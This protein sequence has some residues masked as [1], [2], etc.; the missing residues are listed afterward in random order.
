MEIW[1]DT[2]NVE[3]IRTANEWGI[4][5][6]VTTNTTKIAN[7]KRSFREIIDEICRIMGDKPVSVM[8]VQHR[9]KKA[10]EIVKDG[11]ELVEWHPNIVVK[12]PPTIEG[13]K[14]VKILSKQGIKTNITLVYTVSQALLSAKMGATYVSPFV[15]RM[16]YVSHE[17]LEQVR[18]I[19]KVF[20]NYNFKTKIVLAAVRHP[21]HFVKGALIGV[22]VVT[23]SFSIL[24]MLY[25]H[26]L[27]DKGLKQFLEDWEKVPP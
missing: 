14:A 11:K 5:D 20:D 27:T 18:M 10:E 15:G 22:D 1:A 9:Y 8:A 12:V 26:P 23:A 21:I 24:K 16:D 13:L 2:A 25:E 7:E 17:G 19:R 6:G 4:I 3:E